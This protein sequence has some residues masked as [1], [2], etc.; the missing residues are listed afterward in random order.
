MMGLSLSRW[1]LVLPLVLV[2]ASCSSEATR[3][4]EQ[5]MIRVEKKS[6]RQYL[7]E[8]DGKCAE[9]LAQGKIQLG[10]SRY[11]LQFEGRTYYFAST[12][13]K[14]RFERELRANLS[15]AQQ[16]WINRGNTV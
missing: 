13:A 11:V 9:A 8:F 15:R 16:N 5:D 1:F 14:A 4:S 12:E 10:D 2:A 6:D 3:R 7:V